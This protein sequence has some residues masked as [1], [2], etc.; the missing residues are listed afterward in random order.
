VNVSTAHDVLPSGGEVGAISFVAVV[1]FVGVVLA[2]T[3]V[4]KLQ[5]GR[6]V[7]Q[8]L[9]A[10]DKGALCPTCN[11]TDLEVMGDSARCRTCGHVT[12]LTEARAMKFDAKTIANIRDLPRGGRDGPR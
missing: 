6:H 12:N 9:D 3:Y 8:R 11:A 1:V 2:I 10:I 7:A 5:L 4:V